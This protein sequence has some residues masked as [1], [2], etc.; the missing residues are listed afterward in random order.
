MSTTQTIRCRYCQGTRPTAQGR[1]L[2]CG[3]P[4]ANARDNS[5]P[6]NAKRRCPKCGAGSYRTVD[7][8]RYICGGCSA[9]YED[10]DVGY[11]HTDPAINA[12]KLE[13]VKRVNPKRRRR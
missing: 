11:L 9:V 5:V 13:T 8:C 10:A 3:M 1:C 7:A 6:K 12:E 4:V 2:G